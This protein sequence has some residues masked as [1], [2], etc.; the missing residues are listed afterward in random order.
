VREEHKSIE[1]LGTLACA[2]IFSGANIVEAAQYLCNG[3]LD[4]D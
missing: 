2:E 4:Q 1:I 3:H